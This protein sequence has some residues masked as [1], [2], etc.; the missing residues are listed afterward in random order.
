MGVV[1]YSYG[2]GQLVSETRAGVHSAYWF[3]ALGNT[4]KLI[5]TTSLTVT[6]KLNP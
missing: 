3:D 2:N 4:T 1:N 6:D 5:D